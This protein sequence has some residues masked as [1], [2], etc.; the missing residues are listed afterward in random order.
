MT[1]EY[2]AFVRDRGRAVSGAEVVLTLRDLT[3]G[4]HKY[5]GIN[6]RAVVSEAPVP[7]EPLLWLRSVVGTREAA[8]CSVRITEEL[9]PTFDAP[10]YSDYFKVMEALE[11]G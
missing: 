7:G 11:K 9:P 6:V 2:E 8:P 1:Q 4:R 5:R 10:P 3:P